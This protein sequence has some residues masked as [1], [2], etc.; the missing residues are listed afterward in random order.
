MTSKPRRLRPIQYFEDMFPYM[1]NV[2][3]AGESATQAIFNN[4]WAPQRYTNGQTIA[5]AIL[6]VFQTFPGSPT[7][8]RFWTPQFSSL[9]SLASIGRS[10]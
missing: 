3:F 6:D 10:D 7:T 4:A 8:P 1:K 2:D 5:L 9:Y